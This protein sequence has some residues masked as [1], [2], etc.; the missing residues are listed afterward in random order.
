MKVKELIEYLKAL[1]P[2]KGIWVLYDGF[3]YII[4]TP[5][6]TVKD[7]EI[8]DSNKEKGVKD[9]DYIISAG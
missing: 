7:D 5:D 2:E 1:D 4:P 8:S 6:T 3:S 9:G